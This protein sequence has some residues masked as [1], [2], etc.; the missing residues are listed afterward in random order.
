MFIRTVVSQIVEYYATH[1]RIITQRRD[2]RNEAVVIISSQNVSS[3]NVII[4]KYKIFWGITAFLR[5]I[6]AFSV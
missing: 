1:N 2:V 4:T 3:S 5:Q 6:S